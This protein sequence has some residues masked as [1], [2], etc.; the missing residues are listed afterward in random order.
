VGRRPRR[1]SPVGVERASGRITRGCPPLW[2]ISRSY[3]W[4]ANARSKVV[5][6][7]PVTW[8]DKDEGFAPER[9]VRLLSLLFCCLP[10]GGSIEC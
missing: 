6:S 8:L 2:W 3:R 5:D 7:G 9:A 4:K 10:A 1:S